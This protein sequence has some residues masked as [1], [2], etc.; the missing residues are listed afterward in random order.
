MLRLWD[1]AL[2][3][4]HNITADYLIGGYM[5]EIRTVILLARLGGNASLSFFTSILCVLYKWRG[6]LSSYINTKKQCFDC[7]HSL[8]FP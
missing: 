5:V 4:L 2:G 6:H 7:I 8:L 3:V 1:Q